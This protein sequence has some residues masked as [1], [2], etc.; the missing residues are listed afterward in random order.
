MTHEAEKPGPALE[1]RFR[2]RFAQG[3]HEFRRA[4]SNFDSEWTIPTD[5]V[6][7]ITPL[8]TTPPPPAQPIP[9]SG[10]ATQASALLQVKILLFLLISLL[11]CLILNL[12]IPLAWPRTC[13]ESY[14]AF[15]DAQAT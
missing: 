13:E 15:S 9:R 5:P 4:V 7:I 6:G 10:S 3:R 1:D 12:L 8:K 11:I 2:E 14:A